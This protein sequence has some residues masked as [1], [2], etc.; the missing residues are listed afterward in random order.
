MF[1]L[2]LLFAAMDCQT[3]CTCTTSNVIAGVLSILLFVGIVVFTTVI[4]ICVRSRSKK[5]AQTDVHY[6]TINVGHRSTPIE[7]DINVAYGHISM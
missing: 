4:I 3:E 2:S 7:T 5:E 1:P 6:D